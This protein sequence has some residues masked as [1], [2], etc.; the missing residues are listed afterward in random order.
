MNVA[1]EVHALMVAA[2]GYLAE[3]VLLRSATLLP[4]RAVAADPSWTLLACDV[5]N[6]YSQAISV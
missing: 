3:L 6:A 4:V 1:L 2:C 5:A